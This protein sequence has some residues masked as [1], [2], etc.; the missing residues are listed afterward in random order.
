MDQDLLG[1]L[2][3][4]VHLANPDGNRSEWMLFHI[5]T[6]VTVFCHIYKPNQLGENTIYRNKNP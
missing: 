4:L 1:H 5:S 3:H 2:F 6:L